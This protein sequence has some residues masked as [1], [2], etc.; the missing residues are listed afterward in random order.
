VHAFLRLGGMMSAHLA[1]P[2]LAGLL[3]AT[4]AT[5][6]SFSFVTDE[7]PVRVGDA[8]AK[9]GR[10]VFATRAVKKGQVLTLYPCHAMKLT[11]TD[12]GQ[13]MVLA[14]RRISQEEAAALTG[15]AQHLCD[16]EEGTIE[17]IGDPAHGF[18]AHA[19]GHLINDPHPATETI[20]PRP[21]NA[22]EYW[23]AML[24]YE[25]RVKALTNCALTPF[26]DTAVMCVATRDIAEGEEV[27]APYGYEYWC[28]VPGHQ[29]WAWLTS[30]IKR[31]QTE[32]PVE[33]AATRGILTRFA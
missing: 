2:G 20:L 23:R 14:N 25:V 12:G 28:R 11:P 29:C 1:R 15:Y 3:I 32:K 4:T 18:E 26:E 22:E 9:K 16:R 7:F 24:D 10:G 27:L 30:Q 5:I 17:V 8:G 33:W 13:P 6:D 19:C 21:G 31:L